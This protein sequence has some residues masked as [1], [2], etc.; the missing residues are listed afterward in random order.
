MS[1]HLWEKK[2]KKR[3]VFHII[4]TLLYTGFKKIYI[5]QGKTNAERADLGQFIKVWEMASRWI[6]LFAAGW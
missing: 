3:R 2:K 1:L 4:D 6:E 5:K